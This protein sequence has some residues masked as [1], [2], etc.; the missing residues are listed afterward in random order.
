MSRWLH[1][2]VYSNKLR[3]VSQRRPE[4]PWSSVVVM[5]TPLAMKNV[6]GPRVRMV[7]VERLSSLAWSL[8]W[9]M[10][11]SCT[12]LRYVVINKAPRGSLSSITA[13]SKIVSCGACSSRDREN[14]RKE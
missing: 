5:S 11:P 8:A 2:V 6:N 14:H 13:L 12:R 3:Q 9:S 10:V 7:G 4:F 1:A